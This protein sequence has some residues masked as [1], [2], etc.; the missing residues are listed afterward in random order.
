MGF[1]SLHSWPIAMVWAYHVDPISIPAFHDKSWPNKI[2][3]DVGVKTLGKCLY[4]DIN[5]Q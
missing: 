4:D 3:S 2:F 5:K 1:N